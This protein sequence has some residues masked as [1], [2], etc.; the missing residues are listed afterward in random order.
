MNANPEDL[1]PGSAPG[2]PSL[3]A[4]ASLLRYIFDTPA[5]KRR[6][7]RQLGCSMSEVYKKLKG[8]RSNPLKLALDLLELALEVEPTRARLVID[9]FEGAYHARVA[10]TAAGEWDNHQDANVLSTE[11]C[12]AFCALNV[13][14]VSKMTSRQLA[15]AKA[16]VADVRHHA[17]RIAHHIDARLRALHTRKE[18]KGN[19]LSVV[20]AIGSPQRAQTRAAAR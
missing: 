1:L 3:P 20:R 8:E 14:G 5:R 12:Q 16:E 19:G 11:A 4:T 6:L 15:K 7:R 17:R 18:R 13:T 10:A 2:R 9:L